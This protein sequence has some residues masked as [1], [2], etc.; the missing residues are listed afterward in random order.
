MWVSPIPK[1]T[2]ERNHLIQRMC[3]DTHNRYKDILIYRHGYELT[4]YD[5]LFQKKL[6]EAK[7]EVASEKFM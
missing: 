1:S 7:V 5:K 4:E 3:C 2:L 6:Y